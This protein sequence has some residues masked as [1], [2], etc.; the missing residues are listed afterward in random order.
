VEVK[1]WCK[2][3]FTLVLVSNQTIGVRDLPKYAFTLGRYK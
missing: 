3:D 1:E 2:E